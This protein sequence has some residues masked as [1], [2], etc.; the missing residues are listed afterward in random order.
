MKPLKIDNLRRFMPQ[1]SADENKP[2]KIILVAEK[3]PVSGSDK[4]LSCF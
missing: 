2:P 3:H 1:F 4:T